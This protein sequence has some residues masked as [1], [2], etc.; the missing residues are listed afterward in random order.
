MAAKMALEV[1][2]TTMSTII[3][4]KVAIKTIIG[5]TTSKRV[6]RTVAIWA[7]VAVCKAHVTWAETSSKATITTMEVHLKISRPTN[8]AGLIAM[9]VAPEIAAMIAAV[10]T[11]V[12]T[13]ICSLMAAIKVST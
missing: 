11:A 1:A 6:A 10:T 8:E 7:V 2:E 13:S 4:A 12:V 9:A 3:K 5:R